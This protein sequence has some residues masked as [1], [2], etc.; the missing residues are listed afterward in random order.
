MILIKTK[1]KISTKAWH[2][3]YDSENYLIPDSY[4]V[5]KDC[6]DALN[7]LNDATEPLS[8]FTVSS[9]VSHVDSFRCVRKSLYEAIQE[10]LKR[11]GGHLVRNNFDI[12]IKESIGQD[13]GI[14]VQYKKNLREITC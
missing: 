5:E 3:F 1:N 6:N 4:V 11:W 8:E 2:V 13:H 12:Q 7:H 10:V 14:V 9:D